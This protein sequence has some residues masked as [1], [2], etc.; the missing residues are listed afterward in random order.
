MFIVAGL[1]QGKPYGYAEW[2][3]RNA[4]QRNLVICHSPYLMAWPLC[5]IPSLSIRRHPVPDQCVHLL[6]PLPSYVSLTAYI[7]YL[8]PQPRRPYVLTCIVTHVPTV[9]DNQQ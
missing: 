2:P 8:Q 7:Q 3:R 9:E 5:L 1:V 6:S 4:C